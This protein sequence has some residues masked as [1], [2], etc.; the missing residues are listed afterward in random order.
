[1]N[2]VLATCRRELRAYFFSPLAYVV[3]FFFLVGQRRR[4][5]SIWWACLNDPRSPAAVR[6]SATSSAAPLLLADAPAARAGAHHAAASTRSCAR[7]SIEVLMT[8]PVTESQV[9]VGKYLAAL[10]FYV[11]L[12]LPTLAYG[13][14][15]LGLLQTRSTGGR[16]PPAIWASCGSARCSSPSASSPRRSR[17]DQLRGGDHHLRPPHHPLPAAACSRTWSTT[18]C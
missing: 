4:S 8:A 17:A 2:G 5:S 11:F 14:G 3:L 16:S 1:M 7:G 10:T 9:V 13:G 6:R 18:T 15:D 12:W